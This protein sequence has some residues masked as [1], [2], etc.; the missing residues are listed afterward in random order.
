MKC[1][2]QEGKQFQFDPETTAYTYD[3]GTKQGSGN[4]DGYVDGE[5]YII[6]TPGNDGSSIGVRIVGGEGTVTLNFSDGTSD[7][8]S[9]T[10]EDC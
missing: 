6:N 4:L 7:T 8:I 3:T 9:G 1:F 10:V 2:G 5:P